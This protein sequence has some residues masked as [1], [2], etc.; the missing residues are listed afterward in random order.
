MTR[1]PA[2][3][4]LSAF[5]LWGCDKLV[6]PEGVVLTPSQQV[7]SLKGQFEALLKP[8]AAY[9]AQPRCTPVIVVACSDTVLVAKIREILPGVQVSLDQAEAIVRAD[10]TAI[11][12]SATIQAVRSGL[13]T[14]NAYLVQS[15]T[16]GVIQ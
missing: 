11:P 4:L 1:L 16:Q 15:V 2:T 5:L 3:L 14:L 6:A 13:A 10:P 9:E 12:P 8:L 7:Y